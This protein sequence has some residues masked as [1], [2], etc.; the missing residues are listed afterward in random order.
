[1]GFSLLRG[2]GAAGVPQAHDSIKQKSDYSSAAASCGRSACLPLSTSVNSATIV[3]L[4]PL[5]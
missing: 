5:R 4:P 2:R 3:Q 1:M